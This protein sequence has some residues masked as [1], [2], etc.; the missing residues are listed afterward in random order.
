ME[1]AIS[2]P[3]DYLAGPEFHHVARAVNLGC[4]WAAFDADVDERLKRLKI[5]RR[6]FN[7]RRLQG[8]RIIT[9]ELIRRRV[10]IR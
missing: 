9:G 6:A 1:E 8:L 2:W 4:L 10:P 7:A 5:T 3:A